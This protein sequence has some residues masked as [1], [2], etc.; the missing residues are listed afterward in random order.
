MFE[1]KAQQTEA[2]ASIFPDLNAFIDSLSAITTRR[3]YLRVLG[4]FAAFAHGKVTSFLEAEPELV[5]AF[6][7]SRRISNPSRNGDLVPLSSIARWYIRKRMSDKD[8]TRLSKHHYPDRQ[9]GK[10]YYTWPQIQKIL[11]AC[12]LKTLKGT[13]DHA[14]ISISYYTSS[15]FQT[16]ARLD[17]SDYIRCK[18]RKLLRIRGEKQPLILEPALEQSLERYLSM[19]GRQSEAHGMLFFSMKY[20]GTLARP[21]SDDSGKAGTRILRQ[22]SKR[23]HVPYLPWKAVTNGR[24]VIALGVANLSL[25]TLE[26]FARQAGRTLVRYDSAA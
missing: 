22:L 24:K 18:S 5:E 13:R 20:G 17:C 26:R 9:S 21:L 15:S 6:L 14:L 23:A 2:V 3:A 12:D 11:K 7:D 1:Q 25:K 19:A 4:Y 10:V 16:V 8:P